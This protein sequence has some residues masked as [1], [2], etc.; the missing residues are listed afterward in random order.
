MKSI[1]RWEE[2]RERGKG[3][4]QLGE[5]VGSSWDDVVEA[6]KHEAPAWAVVYEGR[7]STAQSI[8]GL[9][10]NARIAC[11]RPVGAFEAVSRQ[12]VIGDNKVITVYTRYVGGGDDGE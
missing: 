4:A 11:F 3:G 7:R 12:R 1:L 6:L 5:N 2:P 9:I 8:R 10:N